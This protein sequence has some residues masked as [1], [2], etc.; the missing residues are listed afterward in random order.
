MTPAYC[1][2]QYG[3]PTGSVEV[4]EDAV[5]EAAF[6]TPEL[7]TLFKSHARIEDDTQDAVIAVYLKAA[8]AALENYTHRDVFLHTRKYKASGGLFFNWRRG[9]YDAIVVK[10][11]TGADVTATA[12]V[13]H[14]K[15]AH[16]VGFQL[17][18]S[19]VGGAYSTVELVGG[20]STYATMPSDFLAFVLQAAGMFYE[21]R[22]V[23]NYTS[24]VQ[25]ADQLPMY[26]IDAWVIPSF[27]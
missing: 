27:A 19:A 2:D 17:D 16:G 21:V 22:E 8:V 6:V 10:D 7:V 20:Y 25:H 5:N 12:E 23:L 24:M 15:G 26:L 1:C 11:A 13:K 14:S 9:A 18:I 4:V 3:R